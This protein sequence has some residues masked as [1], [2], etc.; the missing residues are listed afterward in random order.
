MSGLASKINN[1]YLDIGASVTQDTTTFR[2]WAPLRK[3]VELRLVRQAK[4]IPMVP[5]GRGYFSV[6]CKAKD[7]QDYLYVLDKKTRR[8]DPASRL[9]PKG[10]H[11]PSRIVDP[12]VFEW[13][14]QSWRGISKKD[15]LIYELHTGTFTKKGDF[16]SVISNLPYLHKELGITAIEIM[17]VGQFPGKRNW[18]YDGTYLYAVQNSYG[19]PSGLK[20]LVNACHS[21][22]LAVI[23]D[24][25]YNH[26]GPEGNYLPD[27]GPYLSSKY[28]TPWGQTPNYD[29]VGS[30][31]VRHYVLENALHWVS[32]YHVD[33]LRLDAVHGIYDHSPKHL[34]LEMSQFTHSLAD[35]L[36]KE[37]HLIAESD[38]NDPIVVEGKESR[39][40]ECDAQWSDDF[41]HAVHAYLTG[42]RQRH[43][44][45]FGR[46]VDISKSMKVWFVYDG[47][48]SKYRQRTF[49]APAYETSGDKFVVFT[50]NHDQVGN[51]AG[52]E[53]LSILVS[54]EKLKLA[55]AL[56]LLSGNLPLLF[57]G[58]EYGETSPFYYF[59]DHADKKLVQAVRK[60]RSRDLGLIHGKGFIDPQSPSTFA[61]SKVNLNSRLE[62]QEKEI[63]EFYQELIRLRKSH[64][65]FSD[66]ESSAMRVITLEDSE[67]ILVSR[68]SDDE[69]ILLVYSF[70]TL[71][72]SIASPVSEGKWDKILDSSTFAKELMTG[73]DLTVPPTSVV[74]YSRRQ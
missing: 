63:F 50:Q 64:K 60:G 56:C 20:N 31:E 59:I 11:G 70:G 62:G 47:K 44:M 21:E 13:T 16:Q 8:P 37:F 43:Y 29:G 49:G 74:V 53:R 39:G 6:T 34:L 4:T 28:H 46:L 68:K 65:I 22:G 24:V 69:E 55:A 67:C 36:G 35:H 52:G 66:F 26:F 25:V 14:D 72:R 32:E 33:G 12:Q 45:D 71:E 19:G 40:Y 48:Y 54:K 2:V 18:G 17:P 42:E 9:Q 1:W 15:L 27:Y 3:S 73:I 57:M 51:R 10:V 58:E 5:D 38:L 23:L 7:G 41:H 61:R 30:D